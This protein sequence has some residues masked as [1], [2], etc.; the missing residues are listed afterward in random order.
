[1][2][3]HEDLAVC[4]VGSR[5]KR[6][7]AVVY[8]AI[9]VMVSLTLVACGSSGSPPASTKISTSA[10]TTPA[11]TGTPT[12]TA[13][14]TTTAVQAATTAPRPSNSSPAVGAALAS[15]NDQGAVS[16]VS[17]VGGTGFSIVD[18]V[19]SSGRDESSVIAYSAS[20]QQLAQIPSADLTG[21]CGAADLT[22]PGVGRF[23]LTELI[24]T[25]PA[26]GI[27][28]ATTA[29]ALKAW[30][31][32]TGAAVWSATISPPAANNDVSCGQYANQ[33]ATAVTTLETF[34]STPDVRWGLDLYGGRPYVVDLA[35]GALRADQSAV[36]TLG[37]YIVD[38]T[39][40]QGASY[41]S[42]PATGRRLAAA[43]PN[44]PFYNELELAPMGV[45]QTDSDGTSPP[46][47]LSTD[48]TRLFALPNGD[49]TATPGGQL[50]AYSLP[51][52]QPLWRTPA[53][54]S[55][56]LVG[57]AG[58]L[59]VVNE[60]DRSG[61]NPQLVALSERTGAVQWHLPTT[62]AVCGLSAHQ[63][64]LSVNNQLATID[65]SSG[66]QIFF[67]ASTGNCPTVLGGGIAVNTG[68]ESG[69]TT[70]T[71]ALVP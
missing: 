8:A 62:G 12:T 16:V 68:G 32:Q 31:A 33:D 47:A 19:V 37:N 49:G 53:S 38:Q 13:A 41:L 64:L 42:D 69:G 14:P 39:S 63:M 11:T 10:T 51:G 36:S 7:R 65:M 57:D 52:G 34:V 61:G 6:I 17:D 45:V 66:K 25:Q 54:V 1:M 5:C 59:L 18:D 24:T 28:P 70:V 35:T 71:Q 9:C 23:I 26:Q 29:V 21:D 30:N 48:G 44:I 56:Y 20:G 55:I 60:S 22:V 3:R 15:V 67:D 50:V 58:R 27:N 40:N 4:F 43:P 46:A 2:Y